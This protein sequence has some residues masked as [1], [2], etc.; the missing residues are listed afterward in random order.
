MHI[1]AAMRNNSANL[2]NFANNDDSQ[3]EYDSLM[4]FE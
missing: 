2:P 3:M 1:D 4:D